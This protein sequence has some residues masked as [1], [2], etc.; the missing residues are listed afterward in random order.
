MKHWEVLKS[1]ISEQHRPK[2]LFLT[3]IDEGGNIIRANSAMQKALHLQS[4]REISSNFF[5]LMHPAD[6]PGFRNGLQ[7]ARSSQI[8]FETELFLKNSQ[9]YPMKWQVNYLG[10][11]GPHADKFLCIGYKLVEDERLAEYHQLGEK[12]YQLIVESLTAGILFHDA[13][14]KFIAGNKKAADIFGRSLE[15]LY[16]YSDLRSCWKEWGVTDEEGREMPFEQTPFMRALQTGLPQAEVLVVKLDTGDTKWVQFNAQPIHDIDQQG[17]A[18]VMTN[19]VDLTRER[20]LH[21]EI[22]NRD[23]LF[24]SFLSRTPTLAWVMDEDSNLHFAS[25]SFY[26]YFGLR[27]EEAVSKCIYDLVPPIVTRS[28][29]RIH[30]E[31]LKTG[32]SMEVVEKA[33]WSDGSNFV[34]HVNIFPIDG[35]SGKRMVGGHAVNLADRFA[36]EKKLQETNER[37]L[38]LSRATS[39]AIWEWDMQTGHIFRNDVLM[40]MIGYSGETAR[41]L[42]W[43]LR[44]IHPE[45]R[46]RVTDTV[47]ELTDK[48]AYSWEGQYRFK[49]A[50]G[51]YKHIRDRGFIV[52]ENGL[53]VR[54]IGSLTDVTGLKELE[55]QLLEE[56]LRKQKEISEMMIRVQEKERSRIGAELHDNVNQILSTTRMFVEML[57]PSNEEEKEIRDKSVEYLLNAIEEIRKISRE[58]VVPQLRDRGLVES[59]ASIV[60]DIGISGKLKIDFTYSMEEDLLSPGKKVSLFRI[61]QEQV[62]N[63]MKYSQATEVTIKLDIDENETRLVIRDNGIGFD[64]GKT[65]RG[66]GLSNIHDRARFYN[67]STDIQSSPGKGCLLTVTIPTAQ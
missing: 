12:N 54:M 67:G 46:N 58:L 3:L 35:L 4:P 38:L 25:T 41:G 52:Y 59:I 24:R 57:T 37:L 13:E 43:W 8:R 1:I 21:S 63:I 6:I 15:E 61:V 17:P 14:G 45:D 10:H 30:E 44:R 55:N 26:E 28:L 22:R 42:S 5:Q 40:D 16:T 31:V 23:S 33:K 2:G 36:A 60:N 7:H 47:K 11:K 53:P 65:Y 34:F 9:Y 29:R 20:E 51:E 64:P 62:K 56:K 19:L 27:E 39:D 32:K 50:D 49:C 66:I 18:T 48:G